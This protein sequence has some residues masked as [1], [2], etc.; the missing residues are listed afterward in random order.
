MAVKEEDF[1]YIRSV[2]KK[3]EVYDQIINA[4][5]ATHA[6]V[7]IEVWQRTPQMGEVSIPIPYDDF[8]YHAYKAVKELALEHRRQLVKRLENL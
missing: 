8:G 6:T 1:D 4:D 5:T 7:G 3:I 2:L